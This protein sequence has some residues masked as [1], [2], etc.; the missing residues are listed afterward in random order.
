ME[1][2]SEVSEQNFTESKAVNNALIILPVLDNV[3]NWVSW[4][5]ISKNEEK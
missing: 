3:Q 5:R 1:E 4:L 2:K